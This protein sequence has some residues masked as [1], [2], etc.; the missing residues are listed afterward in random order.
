[1]NNFVQMAWPFI[2][3]AVIFY[4][5]IYRPQKRDQKKR[6]DMLHA[7]KTGARIMTIGGIYGEITK[8]R[9]ERIRIK[10]AE[11]VEFWIRRSAVGGVVTTEFEKAAAKEETEETTTEPETKEENKAEEVTTEEAAAAEPEAKETEADK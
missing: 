11:N 1:M 2:L 8:V 5:L 3:M 7:L 6:A 9:D 10:V 4:F